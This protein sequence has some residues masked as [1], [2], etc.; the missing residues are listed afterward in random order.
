MSGRF[1]VVP[2]AAIPGHSAPGGPQWHMIRSVLGIEA[3]GANAWHATEAGQVLIEEHDELGRGAGEHEE[4]YVVL[5]GDARFTLEGA[6]HDAPAG[7]VVF[8]K[9]P[10][11]KRSAVARAAGT[12]VLV[13]GGKPGEAFAVSTWERP[14]EALRYWATE[15]WERAIELLEAHHAE[16]PGNAN[17]LYNLACAEARAGHGEAALAHL[18]AAVES[19]P[20]F[21][22]D[23]R[24]DADLDSIREDE[25]FPQ[26]EPA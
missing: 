8:V 5:Q 7:T 9:D 10:A 15:D 3:F 18:A 20:R 26:A 21:R 14:A 4:L 11:V 25:R 13:V 19:E 2:V 6:E 23:A 1:T 12:V 22:E 17:V 24:S 16:D